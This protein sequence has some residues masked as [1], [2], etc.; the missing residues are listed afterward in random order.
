MLPASVF[1]RRV[2]L[3]KARRWHRLTFVRTAHGRRVALR[4][5]LKKINCTAQIVLN[6]LPI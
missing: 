6:G 2:R 1:L 4:Q 3:C 5:C